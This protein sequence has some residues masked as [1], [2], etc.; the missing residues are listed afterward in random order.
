MIAFLAGTGRLLA[1]RRRA[2]RRLAESVR[3]TLAQLGDPAGEAT[4]PRGAGWAGVGLLFGVTA[5]YGCIAGGHLEGIANRAGTAAGFGISAIEI[6]GH[7][8]LDEIEVLQTLDIGPGAS[9]MAF[10][11]R[12]A[13]DRLRDNGWIESASVRKVYPGTLKIALKER[14]PFA[15]WQRGALLSIID[16]NGA[17]ITESVADRFS[18][19]PLFVGHG[20]QTGARDFLDL[21][22]RYPAIRSRLRAAVFVS[23]RRWDLVLDNDI[24]VKLP[25]NGM[26]SAL[27]ELL[28][29]SAESGLMNRDIVAVDLRLKDE[30]VVRLSEEAMVKRKATVPGEQNTRGRET[31]T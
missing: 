29:L 19:L 21:V 17:V 11:A 10:N 23:N 2:R 25:E 12:A 14:R 3:T 30:V 7:V 1:P 18:A 9:L 24:E 20:A 6:S 13:L 27:D 16:S 15:L 4:I 28:T 31:D 8:Q 5:L 22:D 26:E